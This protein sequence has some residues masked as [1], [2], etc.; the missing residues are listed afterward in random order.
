MDSI[1]PILCLVAV[2]D[3]YTPYISPSIEK[4]SEKYDLCLLTNKKNR[5]YGVLDQEIYTS[6]IFTYFAKLTFCIRMALKYKQ[7]VYYC[8][9]N[10]L[11]E[12]DKLS[13]N[14]DGAF[15][16]LRH[17]PVAEYFHEMEHVQ[18]WRKL[19]WFWMDRKY[20]YKQLTTIEEHAF[21]LPYSDKLNKLEY[22][23][24]EIKPIFEYTSLTNDNPYKAIGNG[25]GLA[26]S[27]ALDV[28]NIN[29]QI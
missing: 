27:Y 28:C 26:L 16:Y 2:G 25:E 29:K 11:E 10:K 20:D 7:G 21:Y 12:L 5:L 6:K 17:W 14:N 8:D 22:V 9:I 15:Y 3:K 4:L 13:V 18:Y 24:E 19:I 1:K 23:V